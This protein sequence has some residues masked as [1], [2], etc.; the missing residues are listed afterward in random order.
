MKEI[1]SQN[2]D[3]VIVGAGVAGASAAIALAPSGYRI[4]LL[5]QAV[6]PRDKPCGEGIMP[7]GVAL[8]DHLGVLSR[9][10]SEG[11]LK[12]RGI[13]YQG[14]H[15]NW[16]Q[17]DF[18]SGAGV[19]PFGLV[20][21][22]LELD[23]LLLTQARV[24]PN[25]TVR[26]GFQVTYV[27]QENGIVRGVSGHPVDRL[28]ERESFRAPLTVGADGLQSIFHNKCGVTKTYLRRKRFGVSGHLKGVSGLGPYVEV[29]L[30]SEGEIY[31]APCGPTT[32]CVALL[33]EKK[34]MP[35]FKGDL[36][37]CYLRFL[38]SFEGLGER[39]VHSELLPPVFAVGPL[40]FTVDPCYRG[41]LLLVGDSGGFLDPISGLGITLALKNVQAA[42]P[43]IQTAFASHDF[44]AQMLCTYAV[45]RLRR[46]EDLLQFTRL[47]LDLS[48][49]RFFANRAL[50]RLR[51]DTPLFQ[52]LLGI[53]AGTN[54][55]RDLSLS[56]K[57]SLL[58]G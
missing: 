18:P 43:I 32:A 2:Y 22:R 31:I 57:I 46:A 28:K 56:E 36:A 37:A 53:V 21:R 9:I 15:G 50:R 38:Q 26:E 29:L 16:A 17:A 6:F 51:R 49:S 12:F 3:I 23:Y 44:S 13:R 40:G 33:L 58:I 45:E 24:F 14:R 42:V 55:Y 41:G 19:P 8:L 30:H 48:R 52:K 54:R 25:V 47:M 11:A 27:I 20:M 1:P 34:L 10:L 7:Q 5:D 39:L 4:L 35:F